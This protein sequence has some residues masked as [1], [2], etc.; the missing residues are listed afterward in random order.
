MSITEDL[1]DRLWLTT[2]K[3][4]HLLTFDEQDPQF[5]RHQKFLKEDGLK[6]N[7]FYS[8]SSFLDSE[9]N[10]WWGSGKGLVNFDLKTI[11]SS[12]KIDTPIVQLNNIQ[13]EQEFIDF[14]RLQDPQYAQNIPFKYDLTNSFSEIPPFSNYPREI[15]LPHRINHLTFHFS[16]L[17]WTSPHGLRYIY[18]LEGQDKNWSKL[19]TENIAEYRN[20]SYGTFTFKV[21]AIG[22]S[23][24]WSRPLT[25]TFKILPPWWHT[26]WARIFFGFIGLLSI[27]GYVRL[28]TQALRK[29]QKEL[30]QTVTARTAEVVAQRNE[31]ASKN[32]EILS[33]KE[34]SEELLLNI[35]P[36]Q[37]AEE[38][39]LNGKADPRYYEQVSVLFTDVKNFTKHAEILSPKELVAEIDFCYKAFDLIMEKHN[40]EK[41]K[42][43][44][45]SYMAAGG[46]PEKNSTNALDT[47]RAAFA[48]R[49]FMKEYQAK[50]IQAGYEP[51]EIRIGIHT[52]PVVAGVVGTKKFAYDIWGDTVVIAVR[53]ESNSD[54]GRVNISQTTY[55]LLKDNSEFTF[56]PRG[57]VQ[58]KNKGFVEMY[59]VD[60]MD[61]GE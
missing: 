56:E 7:D 37:T 58:A 49:D 35:L 60:Y 50:R 27:I 13:L 52:G 32:E 21:R 25:Y 47:V 44:G 20:I 10:L 8:L 53:M 38:L 22:A 59:F 43:I 23:G 11:D 41:I 17:D 46:I 12:F 14:R 55:E 42:T 16:A 1:E 24:I 15:I 29:R 31:L 28:R 2:D 51:F 39:K 40:V 18:K 54:V 34:R 19:T 33:E 9:N 48:I 6:A 57:K 30:E 3:G 45:D 36:L 5:I 4:I 61:K 26:L